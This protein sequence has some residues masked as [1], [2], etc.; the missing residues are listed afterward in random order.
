M[1]AV[2]CL[3][4]NQ[5]ADF[6]CLNRECKS[7]KIVCSTCTQE[8]KETINCLELHKEDVLIMSDLQELKFSQTYDS[9]R[10][11]FLK[12][13]EYL[14]RQMAILNK[15]KFEHLGR[16]FYYFLIEQSQKGLKSKQDKLNI[17]NFDELVGYN[18]S[19]IKFRKIIED[20]TIKMEQKIIQIQENQLDSQ[21][22]LDLEM[23]TINSLADEI[24]QFTNDLVNC[25]V[26][27]ES[28]TSY[29][30]TYS[31][32][33]IENLFKKLKKIIQDFVDKKLKKK[34]K[35]KKFPQDE[36]YKFESKV[37]QNEQEVV[38]IVDDFQV[39]N[40]KQENLLNLY[41]ANQKTLESISLKQIQP[42]TEV[43]NQ[44][45]EKSDV[46]MNED[47]NYIFN[48]KTK[49]DSNI[50]PLSSTGSIAEIDDLKI[51]NENLDDYKCKYVKLLNSIQLKSKNKVYR[52]KLS[53]NQ[54]QLSVTCG[55]WNNS[56]GDCLLYDLDFYQSD[57]QL[58]KII[59]YSQIKFVDSAFSP[60]GKF[61]FLTA[62]SR[63]FVYKT[64]Y[65]ISG[66]NI[67]KKPV[68][69]ISTIYEVRAVEVQ[70]KVDQ[71]DENQKENELIAAIGGHSYFEL[72]TVKLNSNDN[73]YSYNSDFIAVV[74]GQVE[75]IKFCFNSQFIAFSVYETQQIS[76]FD[77][78]QK[79]ICYISQ[80]LGFFIWN[81]QIDPN[82]GFIAISGEHSQI[83]FFSLDQQNYSLS[84]L[85]S[86]ETQFSGIITAFDFFKNYVFISCS[87]NS[88][89]I[90]KQKNK[91]Q[92]N[93]IYYEKIYSSS[94][95]LHKM[96]TL[97][98]C[99]VYKQIITG[100]KNGKL[101]RWQF[102]EDF[103]ED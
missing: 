95:L 44:I 82:Y 24:Q 6:L 11:Q 54:K 33:E 5:Q 92:S 65:Q 9:I 36:I 12:E 20:F 22:I 56:S 39:I 48:S 70:T 32:S 102:T 1:K 8:Y 74:Q 40:V 60:C 79:Q 41:S 67:D 46:I 2:F 93:E 47:S 73:Q 89:K 85:S 80:P 61:L 76:L 10:A 64:E 75:N 72:I 19:Q 29:Q 28:I 81:M 103:E 45:E 53:P 91:L 50:I 7:K 15:F 69:K 90:F 51:S 49:Q 31:D 35:K 57:L 3:T 55:G 84:M 42:E 77:I 97:V 71:G 18:A 62:S 17:Q 87:D 21:Q 16:D 83:Q 27:F 99:P 52:L 14:F 66:K 43:T 68:L 26:I 58:K 37:L 101:L 96:P 98:F 100:C 25:Q 63:V 30:E 59:N 88:L 34:N 4:H 38:D 86:I 78:K 13:D 23:T 94:P